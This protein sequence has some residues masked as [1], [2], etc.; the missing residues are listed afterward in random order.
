ML[1]Q[2]DS[3][4]LVRRVEALEARVSTNQAPVDRRVSKK[5]LADRWDVS[6]RSVDRMRE[7]LPDFPQPEIENNRCFWWLN[8]QII[9]FER[10]R[11]TSMPPLA[12]GER[13]KA[14]VNFDTP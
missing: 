14:G 6:P 10:M 13:G 8:A 2:P 12:E 11:A 4:Q 5:S 7:D 9:P 1:N 3:A